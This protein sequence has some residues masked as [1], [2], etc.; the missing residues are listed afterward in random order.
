MTNYQQSF[1]C[2][3]FLAA[4]FAM[5]PFALV[6]QDQPS[7][8]SQESP[9]A[10]T[11]S[12]QGVDS[13]D[14]IP[15]KVQEK[16]KSS[17]LT[18][19]GGGNIYVSFSKR[20]SDNSMGV[21]LVEYLQIVTDAANSLAEEGNLIDSLEIVAYLDQKSLSKVEKEM[22][23]DS[24]EVKYTLNGKKEVSVVLAAND[25]RIA[26]AWELELLKLALLKREIVKLDLL[27]EE[28]I[29]IVVYTKEKDRHSQLDF[30][31]HAQPSPELQRKMDCARTVSDLSESEWLDTLLDNT[32]FVELEQVQ[33]TY[34]PEDK[35]LVASYANYETSYLVSTDIEALITRMN[36]VTERLQNCGIR[37]LHL[38]FSSYEQYDFF[39]YSSEHNYMGDFGN[40]VELE[41]LLNHEEPSHKHSI[42]SG[43]I[44][45][46]DQEL[47]KLY[48]VSSRLRLMG[49]PTNY[50][51]NSDTGEE[52]IVTEIAV[53]HD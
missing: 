29:K 15:S 51:I 13:A 20:T 43:K 14:S 25:G 7:P 38:T 52:Y 37:E 21:S 19:A 23:S 24:L 3:Y 12:S 6:S 17:D 10:H 18:Y 1:A 5:L 8:P 4:L 53:Y 16:I 41:Y 46:L 2:S 11:Y 48:G 44:N 9:S 30:I 42:E 26:D 34:N 36:S 45:I 32:E 49:V 40:L 47:L 50:Y 35:K 31:Y 33:L 22:Y 27:S 39:T 28:R